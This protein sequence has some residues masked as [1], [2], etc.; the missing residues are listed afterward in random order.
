MH[1]MAYNQ[2]NFMPTQDQF[3]SGLDG[4]P[5]AD[6]TGAGGNGPEL[7]FAIPGFFEQPQQR[8]NTTK[9]TQYKDLRTDKVIRYNELD[10]GFILRAN[11]EVSSQL[12]KFIKHGLNCEDNRPPEPNDVEKEEVAK[13]QNE[14]AEGQ[15]GDEPMENLDK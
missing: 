14:E 1:N 4:L 11:E 10:Q 15:D 3:A 2:M 13:V 5:S 9:I 7:N 8:Q 6:P 12:R